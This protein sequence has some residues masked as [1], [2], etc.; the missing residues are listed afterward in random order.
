MWDQL[1]GIHNQSAKNSNYKKRIFIVDDESDI[2]PSLKIGLECDEDDEFKVDTFNDSIEALS[3]YKTSHYDLLL[4]DVKM[5]NINDFELYREIRK[6][7]IIK[8]RFAFWQHLSIIMTNLK[9]IH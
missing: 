6:R 9:N 2:A 5:L 4:L 3:N 1:L 7:D 8:S